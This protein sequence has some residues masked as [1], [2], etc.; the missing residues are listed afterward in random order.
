MADS[1]N[2]P[3]TEQSSPPPFKQPLPNSTAVLILGI[4]S[5]VLNCCIPFVG[6]ICGVIALVLA[7]KDLKLYNANPD[8]YD[9]TSYKNLNA[10]KIT[11]IIGLVIGAAY[12]LAFFLFL[13][14]GSFIESY[15]EIIEKAIEE[16]KNQ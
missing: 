13:G 8:R 5:I 6:I 14:T 10:G 3:V 12:I 1:E 2:N 9:P 16:A 11:G 15:E 7:Q 4:A